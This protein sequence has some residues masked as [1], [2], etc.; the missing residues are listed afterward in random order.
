[1]RAGRHCEQGGS[2]VGH[3]GLHG[4]DY[5]NR[6]LRLLCPHCKAELHFRQ[7]ATLFSC[8]H[9]VGPTEQAVQPTGASRSAQR[10]IERHRRLAPVADLVVKHMNVA[11]LCISLNAGVCAWGFLLAGALNLYDPDRPEIHGWSFVPFLPDVSVSLCMLTVLFIIGRNWRRRP[12]TRR[13]LYVGF[14][15]LVLALPLGLAA[16]RFGS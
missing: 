2:G 11:L 15:C 5:P 14:C 16:F 10:R 6:L 4:S 3:V 8:D 7:G 9:I 13:L 12:E 1:M